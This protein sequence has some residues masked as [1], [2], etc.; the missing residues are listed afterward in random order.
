MKKIILAG[1]FEEFRYYVIQNKLPITDCVYGV[2]AHAIAGIHASEV[3]TIGSFWSKKYSYELERLAKSRI[4]VGPPTLFDVDKGRELAVEGIKKV[5]E[6]ESEEWQA[7]ARQV[8]T[9]LANTGV[10]FSADDFHEK[11]KFE[12]KHH[13]AVGGVF[14]WARGEKLL[15]RLGVK[16]SARPSSH[17]RLVWLY[18]GIKK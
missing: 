11:L 8:I 3:I 12:P 17:S 2:D 6:N 4:R 15:Q 1:T 13:N 7:H 18:Q 14:R 9:Q 5:T 16:E 10:P